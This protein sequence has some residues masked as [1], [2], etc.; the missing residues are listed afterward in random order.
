MKKKK[1]AAISAMM[2]T[3]TVVMPAS[4]RVGQTTLAASERTWA[5]NRAGLIMGLAFS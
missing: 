1:I 3:I 5:I 2:N 4:L